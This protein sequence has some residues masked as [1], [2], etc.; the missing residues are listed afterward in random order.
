MVDSWLRALERAGEVIGSQDP[1]AAAQAR[2]R[3]QYPADTMFGESGTGRD[4][5]EQ[6]RTA[7]E[8]AATRKA[9]AS[10][11]FG[12]ERESILPG[13]QQASRGERFLRDWGASEQEFRLAG[14]R[15]S[16]GQIGAGF[17]W[18]ALA[19]AGAIPFF[20]D[21]AQ[22]AARAGRIASQAADVGRAAKAADVVGDA[23][24]AQRSVDRLRAAARFDPETATYDQLTMDD[25]FEANIPDTVYHVAPRSARESIDAV[26]LDPNSSTWNTGAGQ[27]DMWYEEALWQRLGDSGEMIPTE[28]RPEGIYLFED[29]EAARDYARNGGDIYEVDLSRVAEDG[30]PVIRDP[31]NAHNWEYLLNEERAYVTRL[32]PEGYFRRIEEIEGEGLETMI[33]TARQPSVESLVPVE[34]LSSGKRVPRY[35]YTFDTVSVLDD[36][37]NMPTTIPEFGRLNAQW[38]DVEEDLLVQYQSYLLGPEAQIVDELGALSHWQYVGNNNIQSI[39]RTGEMPTLDSFE[40]ALLDISG[41]YSIPRDQVEAILRTRAEQAIPLLDDL[42]ANSSTHGGFI[43]YR[44]V[45]RA[46]ID[47]AFGDD[48]YATLSTNPEDL[49]GLS[50]TDEAFSAT[51]LS[52]ARA[53]E[54]ALGE[55]PRPSTM[56][57]LFAIEVPNGVGA[58]PVNGYLNMFQPR[59]VGEFEMLLGR[60]TQFRITDVATP[61]DQFELINPRY[62]HMVW[63]PEAGIWQELRT[64]AIPIVYLEVVP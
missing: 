15:F 42:I 18:G 2:L 52:P 16:E 41:A 60:G 3:G 33:Q 50:W 7:A 57:V 28:Y 23:A 13:E 20:G 24:Q 12:P 32:V 29:L 10:A 44:G 37:Q 63:D 14:Q 1:D 22:G 17:G 31:S 39:L 56:G 35:D 46:S 38:M 55:R 62:N 48:F 58:A 43:S 11:L 49:I 54:F 6:P 53:R 8:Q 4:Y 25:I 27:G 61:A 51:S 40:Q 9:F 59:F 64:D 19:M 45:D 34:I 47:A 21:I 26:G 30:G 5:R 36:F